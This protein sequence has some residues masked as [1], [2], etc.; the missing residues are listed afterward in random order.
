VSIL[1]GTSSRNSIQLRSFI[2]RVDWANRGTASV[3]SRA[4]LCGTEISVRDPYGTFSPWAGLVEVLV[5]AEVL[6]V[7]SLWQ[8]RICPVCSA[9]CSTT[10]ID[11]FEHSNAV[12]LDLPVFPEASAIEVIRIAMASAMVA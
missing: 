12:I 7:R 6:P 9:K 3:S 10:W 11:R 8:N 4:I 2:S 5:I 1:A